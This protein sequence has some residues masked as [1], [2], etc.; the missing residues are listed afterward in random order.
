[1]YFYSEIREALKR[2]FSD[3]QGTQLRA[4][5]EEAF[6]LLMDASTVL[7]P[8]LPESQLFLWELSQGLQSHFE[9]F[10]RS[11]NLEAKYGCGLGGPTAPAT[12]ATWVP[13]QPRPRSLATE[14]S[15]TGGEPLL[16]SEPSSSVTSSAPL[17][18]QRNHATLATPVS[19]ISEITAPGAPV[20][21]SAAPGSVAS[22]PVATPEEALAPPATPTPSHGQREPKEESRGVSEHASQ[23]PS[24]RA[25][26]SPA[27]IEIRR[28]EP[29]NRAPE[30]LPHSSGS[31]A[32]ASAEIPTPSSIPVVASEPSPVQAS[33]PPPRPSVSTHSKPRVPMPI[34]VSTP[35][36]APAK[37]VSSPPATEAQSKPRV[38]IA[39]VPSPK[40]GVFTHYQ[41]FLEQGVSRPALDEAMSSYFKHKASSKIRSSRHVVVMDL[42]RN[43]RQKR[44]W[45]LDLETG[46]VLRSS[47]VG[48]G[49]GNG[50]GVDNPHDRLLFVSNAAGSKA[51][52]WGAML[53][54]GPDSLS[55]LPNAVR[56]EG[57]DSHNRNLGRGQREI[58]IHSADYFKRPPRTGVDTPP[59]EMGRSSGC[60]VLYPEDAAWV[61]ANVPAGSFMYAYKGDIPVVDS[62]AAAQR[63][64]RSVASARR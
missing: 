27:P 20:L 44:F 10:V 31:S 62:Q 52:T 24:S 61:G 59:S 43:T 35:P 63:L 14:S 29:L 15:A 54:E 12:R 28:A 4:R 40:M 53:V 34:A 17:Y 1:M 11:R 56:L 38:P 60:P 9:S 13:S 47:F 18:W 26:E 6:L 45:V 37:P 3:A 19:E 48:H 2:R 23:R 41:K 55:A 51:S 21:A 49:R 42:T 46:K 8:T 5:I 57:L 39:F 25:S 36:T 58:K 30:Q 64:L 32:L 7:D 50:L 33:K 22:E 16:R